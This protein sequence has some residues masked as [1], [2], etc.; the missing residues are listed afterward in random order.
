[1]SLGKLNEVVLP[2]GGSDEITSLSVSFGRMRTSLVAAFEILDE[3][4]H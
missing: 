4:D 1:V 2:S 3:A